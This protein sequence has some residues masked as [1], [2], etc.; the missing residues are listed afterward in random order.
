MTTFDSFW[1]PLTAYD[2]L[3][4]LL[5]S[6]ES[7]WHH[8][9]AFDIFWQLITAYHSKWKLMTAFDSL[10]QQMKANDSFWQPSGLSSS[11]ELRSACFSEA[12]PLIGA[13]FEKKC[14][15]PV[16]MSN[17]C[18]N[19]LNPKI[20]EKWL[21]IGPPPFFTQTFV[22][23]KDSE[24]PKMDFK[25]QCL[26]VCLSVCMELYRNCITWCN[27]QLDWMTCLVTVRLLG[28]SGIATVQNTEKNI[29]NC[30]RL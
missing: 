11:Q 4:Q 16:E 7:F 24:W 13:L 22:Y 15:F 25:H 2:S 10:S 27:H 26:S 20:A 29:R 28:N 6:F 17:T 23:Q 8:L 21:S 14:F 1:Q 30:I 19:F 9:T 5:T 18:K 3:W 12:K